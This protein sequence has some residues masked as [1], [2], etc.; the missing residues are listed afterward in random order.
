MGII[1]P[2]IFVQQVQRYKEE[3][4]NKCTSKSRTELIPMQD[5]AQLGCQKDSSNSMVHGHGQ[6]TIHQLFLYRRWLLMRFLCNVLYKFY[7]IVLSFSFYLPRLVT[8]Y[9]Y[10]SCSVSR[11]IS[12]I[13]AWFP[14]NLCVLCTSCVRI[15]YFLTSYRLFCLR[16]INTICFSSKL[17]LLITGY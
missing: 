3:K 9:V 10:I 8:R 17:C 2:T 15:N 14:F 6:A 11:N 13:F 7:K 16:C 4:K 12:A 5:L 1:S